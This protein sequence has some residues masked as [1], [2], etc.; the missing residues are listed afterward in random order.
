MEGVSWPSEE[1]VIFDL[2]FFTPSY[3]VLVCFRSALFTTILHNL[4]SIFLGFVVSISAQ[5][6]SV[7]SFVSMTL[8]LRFKSN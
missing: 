2:M 6:F 8:C 3:I 7:D 1:E 5:N 4:V